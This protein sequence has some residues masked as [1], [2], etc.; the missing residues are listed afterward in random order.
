M[1]IHLLNILMNSI[2]APPL[3]GHVYLDP[4]SGS[5]LLQLLIAGALGAALILRTSWGRIRGLFR[6]DQPNEHEEEDD[7]V[8]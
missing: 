8:E 7:D 3:R 2:F 6:K 5:I 1:H 4:G